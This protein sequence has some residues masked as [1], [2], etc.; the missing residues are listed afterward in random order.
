MSGVI[1]IPGEL[2]EFLDLPGP[3]TLLLRGP[4]GSGKTTLSLALLEAF[5]GDKVL[6][7]SRVPDR[8]LSREY[9]WLGEEGGRAIQVVDTS[10]LE[11]SVHDVARTMRQ[12]REYLLF[13]RQSFEREASRFLW[14][15]PPLQE[16]WSRISTER[17]S[18][19]VID[20]WDALVDSFL[21]EIPTA[22]EGA[23]NEPIPDRN[24]IER[25]LIRR[26]GK[27]PA[28]LVFILEREEQTVLD[29]LVNAVVVTRRET[30]DQR[31]T[32]WISL[33][34][35]RGVRIE[36]PNYPFSLEGGKFEGILPVGPYHALR[37]G[38][39]DPEMEP[40]PGFLWP[41]S[42]DFASSFGR[43]PLG[44]ITLVEVDDDASAEVPNLLCLP[45]AAHVLGMGGR[46]LFLPHPTQTA[47]D[48]WEGLKGSVPRSR[49]TSHARVIVPPGPSA[50]ASEEFGRMG[51]PL[52][53]PGPP[54]PGESPEPSEAFR[55][56]TEG[57]SEGSLGL[58]MLSLRGL[59]GV[60]RATNLLLA[61]ELASQI[62]ESFYAASK[63]GPFHTLLIARKGSPLTES[64]RAI[65]TLRLVMNL[66]HGRI[67]L[68]GVAPWT[69][70]F[71]LKEGGEDRPYQLLRIV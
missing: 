47:S 68:H 1:R 7:T 50:E 41:G 32:R 31:L 9:P 26:M 58:M 14:L 66:N 42:R 30:A 45:V 49:F 36:N 4:P 35:L 37:P 13:T 16:A 54:V 43:L 19:V 17:R 15:P 52:P 59:L 27:V 20:S 5:K 33:L 21:G 23:P 57:T 38:T 34:K 40:L 56:L 24:Q 70:N 60:A 8:E 65:A 11:D 46:V 55:F 69:P 28:H 53:I 48:L 29:Y 64:T 6:V 18:L 62:P 71:V 39:P 10:L 63:V 51:V 61:A 67:F 25:L 2:Q 44:K 22:G 3:Q 12:A